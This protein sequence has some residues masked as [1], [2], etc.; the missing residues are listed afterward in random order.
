MIP[1][2]RLPRDESGRLEKLSPAEKRRVLAQIKAETYPRRKELPPR[3]KPKKEG[4]PGPLLWPSKIP[5][6]PKTPPKRNR[7]AG[8]VADKDEA[9]TPMEV[10]SR[11]AGGTTYRTPEAGRSTRRAGAGVDDL[12]HALGFVK[13]PLD[14]RLALALACHTDA[15]WEAIHELAHAPLLRD[16]LGSHNTRKLVAG[17]KKYRVR[18]VLHDVFHDLALQ[19]PT[20]HTKES[21]EKVKMQARDYRALYKSIAGF[22]E[23]HAQAG[24][25]VACNALYGGE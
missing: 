16:L 23:T 22:V 21:A 13:D 11:L 6:A 17:A 4:E 9:R 10:L 24:A 2:T 19:R 14:Q 1:T 20:R 12:A 18:L 3:G 5:P 7:P 8:R 25:S 15:E